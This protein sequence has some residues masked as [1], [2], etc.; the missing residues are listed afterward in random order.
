MGGPYSAH[1]DFL[2]EL[3]TGDQ[4]IEWEEFNKL[5]P[6][7]SY[8]QDFMSAQL[9]NLVYVLAHVHAGQHAESDLKS[10]MPWWTMQYST[11][12]KPETGRQ[13]VKKLKDNLMEFARQHNRSLG[14]KLKKRIGK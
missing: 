11:M 4:L 7:G 5:E 6:I 2:E 9:C 10:F 3:L 12:G 1:P 14:R 8:K 13:S